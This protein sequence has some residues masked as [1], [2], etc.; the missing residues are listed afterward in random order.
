MRELEEHDTPAASAGGLGR[1]SL[2]LLFSTLGIAA[3]WRILYGVGLITA[4]AVA[5]EVAVILALAFVCAWRW[6][7]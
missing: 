4:I 5:G 2:L 1:L 6:S 3:F 7:R